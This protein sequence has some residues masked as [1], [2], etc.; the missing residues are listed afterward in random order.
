[1]GQLRDRMLADLQLRFYRPGTQQAYLACARRYAAYYMVSP[2]RLG[3]EDA[4]AYL[5]HLVQE[6]KASA[7]TLKMNVA[8]LK[9]LYTHTLGRPEVVAAIPWPRVRS[10]LPVILS[11]TEV[12]A[13]LAAVRVLKYRAIAMTMYGTGLRVQETCR[14]GVGDI[15][16]R[17]GLIH[18]RDGKRGR[19]RYVMLAERLLLVLREYWRATRPEGSYLFSG[20]RADRPIEPE[21]VRRAIRE[22]AAAAGLVKRVTPHILRHSF[23]THLLEGGTDLRVIQVLLGHGSIRTTTRYTRV[24]AAHVGRTTS[25]LDVLGTSRA[26]PLG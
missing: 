5:V 21:S 2:A 9:F 10:T 4:R 6:K 24:S 20:T 26:R 7:A 22:A 3:A 1:M 23:A 15:D 16:S 18:V 17:R 14:L 11:G 25:P 12:E 19:D 13:F 8:A